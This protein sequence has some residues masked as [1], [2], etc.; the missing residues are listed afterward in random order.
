MK[1]VNSL[2]TEK[3]VTIFC[4]PPRAILGSNRRVSY[5]FHVQEA[6]LIISKRTL[7]KRLA[8]NQRKSSTDEI[9]YIECSINR[10]FMLPLAA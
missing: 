5:A 8:Q 1:D 2:K 7:C 10:I 4:R 9:A 3:W 6:D